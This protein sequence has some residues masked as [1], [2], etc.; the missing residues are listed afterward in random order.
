MDEPMDFDFEVDETLPRL[1]YGIDSTLGHVQHD[2]NSN[3]CNNNDDV[4]RKILSTLNLTNDQI[5]C[6]QI[7]Y[8]GQEFNEKELYYLCKNYKITVRVLLNK[9]IKLIKSI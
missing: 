1:A 8:N 9:P 4:K 5:Y 2:G 6:I 7:I 3:D